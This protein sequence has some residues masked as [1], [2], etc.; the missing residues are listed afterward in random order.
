[1]AALTWVTHHRLWAL[2]TGFVL[3]LA[4]SAFAVWFIVLRSPAT[5][6]DLHQALDLY[7]REQRGKASD[8]SRLP[9]PGV[10]RYRTSG[11][12]QLSIGGIS[13]SFP[14][15]SEMIVTDAGCATLKWEPLVQHME[16]LVECPDPD[17]SLS[18]SSAL[19]YEEI[20]GTQTNSVIRCPA[21]TYLVPPDPSP[22]TR[23]RTTCHSPG[24][25]VVF[26]G[27]VVGNSSVQVGRT[28]VPALH[29]RLTLTFSGP[30]SGSNPNDYWV[31][32]QNGMILRQSETVDVNQAAGPLGAVHYSEQMAIALTSTTP[33]R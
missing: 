22:G 4:A 9:P 18:I 33:M 12:E 8:S 11:G 24:Q 32:E 23:W 19:S 20:A 15:A 28:R 13:R 25:T 14:S 16:G 3:I 1:V 26:T 30:E 10:Y 7:K 6:V 17:G 2:G 5:K 31:S 29:T 27:Q 21:G